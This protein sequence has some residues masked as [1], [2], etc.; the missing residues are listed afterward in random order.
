MRA[1]TTL[2]LSTVLLAGTLA[3]AQ[4]LDFQN[5]AKK[6]CQ[7]TVTALQATDAK[8]LTQTLSAQA[9]SFLASDGEILVRTSRKKLADQEKWAEEPLLSDEAELKDFKAVDYMY[10]GE[11]TAKIVDG[12]KQYDLRGLCVYEANGFRWLMLALVPPQPEDK[13]KLAD[14]RHEITQLGESWVGTLTQGDIA[15][16]LGTMAPDAF[17]LAMVGPDYGFYVFSD[18]AEVQAML[19]GGD[20][21]GAI[22]IEM[23]SGPDGLFTPQLAAVEYKWNFGIADFQSVPLKVWVHLYHDKDA[24]WRVAAICGLPPQQ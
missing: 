20:V 11:V 24:G 12:D 16:M 8:P 19:E 10:A 1:L 22:T 18:P 13:Q 23:Q 6:L 15:R 9:S 21:N 7:D 4:A 14:L 17:T 5:A 2:V 3:A